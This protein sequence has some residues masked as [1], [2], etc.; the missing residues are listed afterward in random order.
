MHF[1]EQQ[2]KFICNTSKNIILEQPLILAERITEN[3]KYTQTLKDSELI[4]YACQ[5]S[6]HKLANSLKDKNFNEAEIKC[7]TF[8]ISIFTKRIIK[9]STQLFERHFYDLSLQSPKMTSKLA[10][11]INDV[12]G[13]EIKHFEALFKNFLDSYKN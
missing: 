4:K 12:S 13:T 9:R 5:Y 11:I 8:F 6:F 3:F 7:C 10:A 2:L 1:N